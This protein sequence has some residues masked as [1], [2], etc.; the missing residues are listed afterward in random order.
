MTGKY[1]HAGHSRD[2]RVTR[3]RGVGLPPR[4]R[5]A[6]DKSIERRAARRK[7]PIGDPQFMEAATV[8]LEVLSALV[9]HM[10]P[11]EK[12]VREFVEALRAFMR[13]E[14]DEEHPALWEW[15]AKRIWYEVEEASM[16]AARP[17]RLATG[18][19]PGDATSI[20]W[21]VTHAVSSEDTMEHAAHHAVWIARRLGMKLKGGP[22]W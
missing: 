9:P 20:M 16:R 13:G 5:R 1:R 10:G 3:S 12:E 18:P 14:A 7:P 17:G 6:W 8:V 2:L 4:A 19:E 11:W 15:N 21:D 22:Q